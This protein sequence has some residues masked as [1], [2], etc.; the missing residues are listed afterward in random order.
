MRGA[1]VV[2]EIS[3]ALL[4]LLTTG[5]LYENLLRLK[6]AQ[7]GFRPDSVFQ[8]RVFVQA[9]YKSADHVARFCDRLS[10]QLGNLPGVDTAGVISVA[11]LSGIL[12]TVPFTVEGEA[13]HDRD[14]PNVN[15]RMVSPGYFPAVGISLKSGRTLAETDRSNTPACRA[16]E[17][18][19]SKTISE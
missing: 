10:E 6:S 14:R 16:G 19:I 13:Q 18:R 5:V 12:A 4:L 8:A 17:C 7:L 9:S 2:A 3:A 1:L 15:L 11:P